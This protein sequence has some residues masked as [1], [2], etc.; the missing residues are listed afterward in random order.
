[1]PP[2]IK[3]RQQFICCYHPASTIDNSTTLVRLTEGGTR[4]DSLLGFNFGLLSSPPG[5]TK[6]KL[7]YAV[8]LS[9]SLIDNCNCPPKP[10]STIFCNV[11]IRTSFILFSTLEMY[12]LFVPHLFASCS[13]VKPCSSLAS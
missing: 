13:W 8:L 10:S 2:N 3:S 7:L 5:N 6:P 9:Y 4:S 1:M 11:E 12:A